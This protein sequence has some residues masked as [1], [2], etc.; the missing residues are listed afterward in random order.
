MRDGSQSILGST[1][2][3]APA[4]A[5]KGNA[6]A[7]P[8]AAAAPVPPITW[9][10]VME[11]RDVPRHGGTYHLHAGKEISSQG[12]D[13]KALIRA[14]VKLEPCEAPAWWVENQHR[15]VEALEA[16][17]TLADEKPR[18]QL[19]ARGVPGLLEETAPP[20]AG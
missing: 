4:A 16:D 11:P 18:E 10:R 13:I 12:Y 1:T 14:G 17:E 6:K 20:A 19:A 3:A 15:Q 7:K 9:H 5:K 2:K 8:A